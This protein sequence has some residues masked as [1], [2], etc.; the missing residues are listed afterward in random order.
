MSDLTIAGHSISPGE[1]KQLMIETA[2]LYDFTETGIPVMVMRGRKPGPVLFVSAAIHGDEI[3]GVDI[4]KRLLKHKRLR[5][6]RGCLIAVPIVNVFGFNTKTRYLPDRRDLNRCFPGRSKG[7][8]GSQMA[9]AF[10][11]EIALKATHGIDLHTGAIHR[12]NL[13]QIRGRFDDP[14]I[15]KMAEAFSAP[16]MIHSKLREGSLRAA[17]YK[18]TIPTILFEGGE[19]LRFDETVSRTGVRGIIRVMEAIGMLACKDG[20]CQVSKSFHANNS[21]WLRATHSGILNAN[22]KLGDFVKAKE[23]LGTLSDPFS[24]HSFE[25]KAKKDGIIIGMSMIPLFN[26][27]DAVFHI[28]TFDDPK[29]VEE[30]IDRY[31]EDLYDEALPPVF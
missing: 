11:N 29:S 14:E 19:A 22:K 20:V 6:L 17:T 1:R 31:H 2:P 25:I 16:V 5:Y 27:G 21:H 9:Y 12:S 13:P 30:N 15:N 7:S 23:V 24:S 3:N 8:L 26:R 4:V 18:Q 28:A 10:F